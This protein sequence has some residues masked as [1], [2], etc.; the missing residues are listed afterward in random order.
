MRL[1]LSSIQI[2]FLLKEFGLTIDDIKDI[3][4]QQWK[5]MREKCFMIEAEEAPEDGCYMNKRCQI[6]MSIADTLY[7]NLFE[8]NQ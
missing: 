4:K 1:K 2:E 7:T 5:N 3:D 6:A 8:E